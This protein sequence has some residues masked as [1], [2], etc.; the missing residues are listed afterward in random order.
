MFV[1]V[2][3]SSFDPGTELTRFTAAAQ[4]AGAVV[5]FTGL[6]RDLDGTLVAMEIEHYPGMTL[7]AVEAMAQ[8]AKTRFSLTDVLIIHRYGRLLSNEPIMMVAAASPH[9]ADAFAAADYLM[10]WL[11]SRAPFWKK[12]ITQSGAQWVASKATDETSLSRWDRPSP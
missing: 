8:Q 7:K 6:V 11:K 1:R 10:D 4:G 12:E 5:S 9:R 2:E 3:A